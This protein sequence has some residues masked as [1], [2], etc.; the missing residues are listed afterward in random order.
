[1]AHLSRHFCRHTQ[2]TPQTSF[3]QQGGVRF[4]PNLY[5][6]GKV[7]LSILGTWEGPSWSSALGLSSVL[8]SIQSLLSPTPYY[9]V[10]GAENAARP[11]LLPC[12]HGQ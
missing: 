12:W 2:P 11:K 6:N 1:M 4:N 7:C 5:A 8:L 10:S 9:N 3:L